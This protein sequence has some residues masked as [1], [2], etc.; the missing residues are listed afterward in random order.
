MSD[1]DADLYSDLYGNDESE[2]AVPTTQTEQ[3]TRLESQGQPE[4]KLIQQTKEEP[5]HVAKLATPTPPPETK[6]QQSATQLAPTLA[7]IPSYTSPPTQQ[8][9][10]YQERQTPEYREPPPARQDYHGGGDVDRPVRPSE[11]KEEG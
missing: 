2:F 11:M 9:P 8:I 4:E 1:L 3:N 6:P 5:A 7:A 10:T